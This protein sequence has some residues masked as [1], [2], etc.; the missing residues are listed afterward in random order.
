MSFL[1]LNSFDNVFSTTQSSLSG[2]FSYQIGPSSLLIDLLFPALSVFP[3]SFSSLD[4]PLLEEQTPK[5]R[6]ISLE[7]SVMH[8]PHYP[9]INMQSR[10][11]IF[12]FQIF[13]LKSKQLSNG[14]IP[15]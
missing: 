7:A 8:H 3:I 15:Q 11:F 10:N 2:P 14:G 9:C 4:P 13:F 1:Q 6:L 12:V 5:L